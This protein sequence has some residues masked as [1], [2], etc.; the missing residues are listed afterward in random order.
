MLKMAD[1]II[2]LDRL[3][4]NGHLYRLARELRITVGHDVERLTLSNEEFGLLVSA[5][6]LEEGI[7]GISDELSTLWQV[8]VLENPANLTRDALQLRSHLNHLLL[9]GPV[10]EILQDPRDRGCTSQERI[11]RTIVPSP[12]I[13]F[14]G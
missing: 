7:A 13:L 9:P 14:S 8:Y 10:L 1:Q 6:T 2:V 11:R 5:S 4:M 12:D 3:N